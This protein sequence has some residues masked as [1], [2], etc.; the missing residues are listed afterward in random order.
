M[1]RI[2]IQWPRFGPYHLARLHAAHRF[3]R[4]QGVEVVGV[5]TA[6]KDATYAWRVEQGATSFRRAQVFPDH[7]FEELTPAEIHTG[8]TAALDRIQP[9]AVAINSYSF[10]DARACLAWCR[11]H[12]R[13]AVVM[14]DSKADDAIRSP[15]RERIKALIVN[16]FDAALLAGTPHRAYFEALGFPSDAIFL[17]YDVVDNAFFSEGAEEAHRNRDA[18][19]H[20]PGLASGTPFFLASNR[21]VP[22]KNMDGLLHAYKAYREQTEMPWQ[23]VL[24]GDGPGRA[25]VEQLITEEK[26]A[27]VTLAGFQQID[28]L[29]A[30][31]GLASGFIHPTLQDQWGLVV[32]EAM[33]AG[34][35]VLVSERAGCARDLVQ[36]GNNGYRFDP[37]NIE[38]MATA[39]LRL[40][41]GDHAEM[42]RCSQDII[43][44]WSP[45]VFAQRLGQAVEVGHARSKR[46]FSPVPRLM[47]WVLRKATRNVQ[48]FHAIKE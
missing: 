16:Q 32:N 29:P 31:Y 40:T 34:L 22:R 27:G 14:T 2:C 12:R 28:E 5:E 7:T 8:V 42:G 35:P 1:K 4:E 39:M 13:V 10:P 47:L 11:R 33:A 25:S 17:G 37:E 43:K 23:L 26:I 20:L 21:F 30:Y 9:D 3:F 44:A 18:Y 48:S 46:A 41:E 15:W 38:H 24:L 19:R 6:G 36:E 45:A